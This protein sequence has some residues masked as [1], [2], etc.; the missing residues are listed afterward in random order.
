MQFHY[1]YYNYYYDYYDSDSD[2]YYFT[3][4]IV[5]ILLVNTLEM[6]KIHILLLQNQKLCTKIHNSRKEPPGDIR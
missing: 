4:Y 3:V 2:Y 1:Y 6:K 5:A